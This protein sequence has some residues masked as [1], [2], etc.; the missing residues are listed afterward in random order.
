MENGSA[1]DAAVFDPTDEERAAYGNYGRLGRNPTELVRAYEAGEDRTELLREMDYVNAL[2]AH[3]RGGDY[4]M[5]HALERRLF[6]SRTGGPLEVKAY[7]GDSLRLG[8]VAEMFIDLAVEV[9]EE[10][11]GYMVVLVLFDEE[12]VLIR[13]HYDLGM[14]EDRHHRSADLIFFPRS[15]EFELNTQ[16][17][18]ASPPPLEPTRRATMQVF[19]DDY[20]GVVRLMESKYCDELEHLLEGRRLVAWSGFA[21]KDEIVPHDEIVPLLPYFQGNF[22]GEAARLALA[23]VVKRMYR[24]MPDEDSAIE[25]ADLPPP[26]ALRRSRNWQVRGSHVVLR[27]L[28]E[29]RRAGLGRGALL[30]YHYLHCKMP[31]AMF[32][33]IL[34]FL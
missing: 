6:R 5:A 22:E 34:S 18:H 7:L 31:A 19:A 30:T 1:I 8:V 12:A 11:D 9:G 28:L 13:A 27:S 25:L 10:E 20:G 23:K 21:C 15:E 3:Q 29:R 24:C 16:D 14:P 17:A 4:T 33:V 2:C 26:G 32:R